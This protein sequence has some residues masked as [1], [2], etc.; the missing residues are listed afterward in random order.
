MTES[1]GPPSPSGLTVQ[2][3]HFP[4]NYTSKGTTDKCPSDGNCTSEMS[5][6]SHSTC[7][8][9]EL[10]VYTPLPPF[11]EVTLWLEVSHM[12]RVIQSNHGTALATQ[13]GVSCHTL[14][15]VPR[16]IL[17]K[18]AMHRHSHTQSRT[19]SSYIY[20][21]NSALMP[22]TLCFLN[23]EALTSINRLVSWSWVKILTA[24]PSQ[25][26][27]SNVLSKINQ[28]GIRI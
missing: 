15:S 5:K 3:C 20:L 18:P 11:Y 25:G 26:P 22:E 6:A 24:W 4:W 10:S 8:A 28:D 13:Q 14:A 19:L 1:H 23:L 21:D 27:I 17:L 16:T 2:K 9:W 12:G 7:W